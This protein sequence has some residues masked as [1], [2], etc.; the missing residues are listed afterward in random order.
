MHAVRVVVLGGGRA[1]RASIW[2]GIP[3]RVRA[4]VCAQAL[5]KEEGDK[6]SKSSTRTHAVA[7]SRHK[8]IVNCRTEHAHYEAAPDRLACLWRQR[9]TRGR[10]RHAKGTDENSI[11][12]GIP[13]GVACHGMVD[14]ELSSLGR[15][16]W[17]SE[18]KP[19]RPARI[20]AA[21]SKART[22]TLIASG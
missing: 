6:G 9:R 14:P 2:S 3:P 19:D 1:A 4:L 10:E 16:C 12:A 17:R 7:A 22:P 8:G 21:K 20:R 15:L 11:R 5:G 18:R 13:T